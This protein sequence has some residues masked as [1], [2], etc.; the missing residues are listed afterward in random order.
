[1]KCS[2]DQWARGDDLAERCDAPAERF[3]VLSWDVDEQSQSW[4]RRVHHMR[5]FGYCPKH[6]PIIA[7][8]Q[9]DLREISREE[10]VV[11]EIQDG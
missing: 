11:W 2:N 6:A 4:T 10:A 8:G 1:M 9:L 7:D 3:F 5:L